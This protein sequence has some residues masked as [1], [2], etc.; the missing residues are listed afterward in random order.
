VLKKINVILLSALFS[1]VVTAGTTADFKPENKAKVNSSIFQPIV[2]NTA[3]KDD[4]DRCN[5]C[6]PPKGGNW[7]WPWPSGK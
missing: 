1:S 6:L 2:V 3:K 7:P 4:K 5:D